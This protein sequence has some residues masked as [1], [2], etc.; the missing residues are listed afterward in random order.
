MTTFPDKDSN[1][2]YSDIPRKVSRQ[3]T[4]MRLNTKWTLDHQ[5]NCES[6]W[7]GDVKSHGLSFEDEHFT[8]HQG[9]EPTQH[10][11]QKGQTKYGL[12]MYL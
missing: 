3:Q 4:G 2:N 9:H 12:Y 7:A 1:I 11:A 6:K 10:G 5:V 8:K